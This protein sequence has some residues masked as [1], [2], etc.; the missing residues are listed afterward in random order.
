MDFI[1]FA[2]RAPRGR[3]RTKT[4]GGVFIYSLSISQ[5]SQVLVEPAASRHFGC[6]FLTLKLR[7]VISSSSVSSNYTEF[8]P[9]DSHGFTARARN[10]YI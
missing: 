6:S 5:I 2:V 7:S 10:Q 3:G 4:V 9:T 1:A 8:C